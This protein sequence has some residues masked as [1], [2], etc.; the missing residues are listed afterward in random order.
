[1]YDCTDCLEVECKSRVTSIFHEKLGE[2]TGATARL[3]PFETEQKKMLRRIWKWFSDY[4]LWYTL[5]ALQSW[6]FDMKF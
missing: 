4:Y 6:L 2:A 5:I 1:M 3:L